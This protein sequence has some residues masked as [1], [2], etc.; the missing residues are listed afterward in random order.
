MKPQRSLLLYIYGFGNLGIIYIFCS[1]SRSDLSFEHVVLYFQ[2]KV[3]HHI[4]YTNYKLFK[5]NMLIHQCARSVMQLRKPFFIVSANAE[6]KNFWIDVCSWISRKLKTTI[7]LTSFD[8]CF[9]YNIIKPDVLTNHLILIAKLHI[10][11]CK[12]SG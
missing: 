10:Y 4:L 3:L 7:L 12:L 11:H 1:C 5:L 2:Y 8:I 9:G 6:A